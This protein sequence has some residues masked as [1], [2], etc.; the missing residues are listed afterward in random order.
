VEVMEG[1]TQNRRTVNIDTGLKDDRKRM[2]FF[3]GLKVG[4]IIPL[5]KKLPKE[6]YYD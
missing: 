3:L 6:Y 2:D 5:F 4:W 1:F